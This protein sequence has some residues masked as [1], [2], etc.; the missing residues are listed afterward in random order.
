MSCGIGCRS[1][2]DLVLLWL[3]QRLVATALIRPLVWEPPNVAGVA[4]E[5]TGEKKEKDFWKKLVC[6]VFCHTSK[7]EE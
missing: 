5:K 6:C 1:G 7:G 2:L 3:W 4:L